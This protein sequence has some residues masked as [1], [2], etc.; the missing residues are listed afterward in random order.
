VDEDWVVQQYLKMEQNKNWD[1]LET[2]EDELVAS[3]ELELYADDRCV[4]VEALQLSNIESVD[5]IEA[6]GTPVATAAVTKTVHVHDSDD[7]SH[8]GMDSDTD[9]E[10]DSEAD[11]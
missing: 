11:G 7:S 4:P 5:G 3:L 1:A 9:L 2:A 8:D 10:V 6:G